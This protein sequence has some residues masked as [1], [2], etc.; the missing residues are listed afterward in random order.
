MHELVVTRLIAASPD[1]VWDVMVNR[2]N[3]WWCPKAV[4]G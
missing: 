4:A 1:K 3:E 2:T